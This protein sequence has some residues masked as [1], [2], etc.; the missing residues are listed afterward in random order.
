MAAAGEEDWVQVLGC[1]AVCGGKNRHVNLLLQLLPTQ[2]KFN[3]FFL[4]K[5][6]IFTLGHGF[7]MK[8]TNGN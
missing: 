6:K 8:N 7:S 1:V 4:K 2:M 3:F 5:K